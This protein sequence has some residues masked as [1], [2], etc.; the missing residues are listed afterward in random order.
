MTPGFE[1]ADYGERFRLRAGMRVQLQEGPAKVLRVT[2]ASAVC[3]LETKL[4][5]DFKTVLGV[6]VHIEAS[7]RLVRISPNSE[8]EV[9]A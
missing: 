1:H 5:K 3:Q 8:V 4:V 9:L 2:P 7:G 6:P